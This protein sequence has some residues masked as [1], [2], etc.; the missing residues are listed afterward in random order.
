[1]GVCRYGKGPRLGERKG[2]RTRKQDSE[3]RERERERGNGEYFG[4]RRM[5]QVTNCTP[6]RRPVVYTYIQLEMSHPLLLFFFLM[7]QQ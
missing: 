3:E 2:S 7:F 5:L 6:L 1:M 4:R